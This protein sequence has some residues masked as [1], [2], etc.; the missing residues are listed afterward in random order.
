M[1]DEL[2]T[3]PPATE[4]QRLRIIMEDTLNSQDAAIDALNRK[5]SQDRMLIGVVGILGG[6]GLFGAWQTMKAVKGLAD[7]CNENF[8]AIKEA[9]KELGEAMPKAAPV[10]HATVASDEHTVSVN[11]NGTVDVAPPAEGPSSQA[12]EHVKEALAHTDM[13]KHVKGDPME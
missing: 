6:L 10:H 9:F 3:T 11:G 4:M 1:T 12:P 8:L 5:V 13:A 2:A 7:Y